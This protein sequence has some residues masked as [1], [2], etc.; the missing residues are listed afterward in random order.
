MSDSKD[1][2]IDAGNLTTTLE[3]LV[4]EEEKQ[5]AATMWRAVWDKLPSSKAEAV[6]RTFADYVDLWTVE[7]AMVR[8][9]QFA[10]QPWSRSEVNAL[11]ADTE[12]AA[13]ELLRLERKFTDLSARMRL[14]GEIAF[15]ALGAEAAAHNASKMVSDFLRAARAL[16][17]AIPGSDEGGRGGGRSALQREERLRLATSAAMFWLDAGLNIGQGASGDGFDEFMEGIVETAE[18]KPIGTGSRK[19][20]QKLIADVR[21]ELSPP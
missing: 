11:V 6:R 3:R 16:Q 10:R 15:R 13:T 4:S 20:L 2:D 7:R 17:G 5:I 8:Y 21:K 19:W 14:S 1:P 12:S 18:G 9:Y